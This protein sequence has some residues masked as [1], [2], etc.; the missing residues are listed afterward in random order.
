MRSPSRFLGPARTSAL[1]LAALALAATPALAQHAGANE[2]ESKVP[3]YTLPDPLRLVDGAPVANATDWRERRRPELLRLFEEHVYG[4]SP[5][6]PKAMRFVVLE[7]DAAAFS[8]RATR[9]QVRVLLDGRES[10]PALEILLYVPNASPR[11]VPAF[12]ALD[13]NGNHAINPDPGIR[14]S[15][16]W[17][18]EGPGV[19]DHRATDATR[20]SDS[21]SW[22]VERILDRGYA[23]ATVNYG[24]IEPDHPEGWKSG[25]RGSFGPGAAGR[26]GVEDW[27][28]IGAWAWGLS[29][30]LDYLETDPDVDAHRVAVLGHSRLGKTALWAGAQ[31]E[32]FAMVVSN[33]SGEGGAALSRR[34][35]GETVEAITRVFPHW[36]APRFAEYAN[37]EDAL[38]VDQHMLLA[39][40]APRPLYVA[41]A[42]DDLWADPRGEFLSAKAAEPVYRLF[43]EDGIGIGEPPAP[44]RPVGATIGY[45]RRSGP[46][47]LTAYDWEQYLD[48]ADRH[49]RPAPAR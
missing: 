30:A 33:D 11:P 42:T 8:G 28:A 38:P 21:A 31:D 15:T 44:D 39:L 16:S 29:R 36:F 18:D 3:A 22:P 32:R 34:R 24:D 10:G 23:L 5:A 4:R 46:H 9:R 40:I 17:V 48:F 43:G 6:P 45:H 12:L 35:F 47:A 1:P 41:S 49:L 14:L 19:V 2:D 27:G 13:F 25:V 26:L 37:H 7:S 20:G